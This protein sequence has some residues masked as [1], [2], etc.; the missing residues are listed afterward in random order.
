MN[1]CSIDIETCGI[2][3]DKCDI[4]EFGAVLDDLRE[5]APVSSLPTFHCYFINEFYTGEPQALAMHPVIFQR[6]ADR[7]DGYTYV[8][9]HKFG[10]MFKKFLVDNGYPQNVIA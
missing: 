5:M 6:I 2:D 10:N 9:A 4:I 8:H 7:T 3:E 1:Y